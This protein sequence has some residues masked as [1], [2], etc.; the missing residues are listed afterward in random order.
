MTL[1]AS[2]SSLWTEELQL[3]L[4]KEVV[5]LEITLELAFQ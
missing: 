1:L 3:E 2:D 5:C 4:H